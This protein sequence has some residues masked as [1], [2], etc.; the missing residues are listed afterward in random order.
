ML[1]AVNLVRAGRAPRIPQDESQATYEGWCRD[2]QTVIDWSQPA[3]RVYDL[4][5]GCNPR[6]GAHT[7]RAGAQLRIFDASLREEPADGAAPGTVVALGPEGF[8]VAAPGGRILARRVQPEGGKKIP[9]VEYAQAS[10]LKVGERL[11][12]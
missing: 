11:R 9:A 4:I 12:S 6:P 2:E 5:R 3:R 8:E 7:R 1:E 10:G